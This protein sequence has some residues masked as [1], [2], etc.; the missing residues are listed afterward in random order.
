[1]SKCFS[2]FVIQSGAH[3]NED[4]IRRSA[5][6]VGQRP[7]ESLLLAAV[8]L[9]K[10]Q[11]EAT[12]EQK[13]L[14][15]EEDILKHVLQKQALKAVKELAQVRL[16]EAIVFMNEIIITYCMFIIMPLGPPSQKIFY[17]LPDPPSILYFF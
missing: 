1:M 8:R 6:P 5:S 13:Q 16:D 3:E 11:P 12:E 9:R 17:S 15:E 2:C 7:K 4:R 10:D 14:A